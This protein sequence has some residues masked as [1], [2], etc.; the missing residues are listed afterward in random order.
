MVYINNIEIEKYNLDDFNSI[1]NRI[2]SNME[3]LPELLYFPGDIPTSEDFMSDEN[4]IVE[5]LK[6][7]IIEAKNFNELYENIEKKEKGRVK[8]K[9]NIFDILRYYILLNKNFNDEYDIIISQDFDTETFL[10]TLLNDVNKI[11]DGKNM[12]LDSIDSII[13]RRENLKNNFYKDI[14]KLIN[15]WNDNSVNLKLFKKFEDIKGV[16]YSKFELEKIEY[17]IEVKLYNVTSILEIFNLIILNDNI[18]F[19]ACNNF[20]KVLKDFIPPI[21]WKNLFDKSKSYKDQFR[22]I[23]RQKNIILKILNEKKV[24]NIDTY[25]QILINIKEIENEN[26]KININLKYNKYNISKEKIKKNILSIFEK[27]EIIDEKDNS[28]NGLFYIPLQSLNKEV[29]LELIMNDPLFSSLLVVNEMF[30]G[31]TDRASIHIYF[32]NTIIGKVTFKITLQKIDDKNN[33][34]N[35]LNKKLYPV[36]SSYLRIKITKAGDLNKVELFQNLLSKLITIY[37]DK[38]N[39]IINKYIN[40]YYVDIG[41]CEDK[42]EYIENE[43]EPELFPTGYK[44]ICQKPVR[45]SIISEEEAKIAIEEGKNVLKFPK[46]ETHGISPKYFICNNPERPKFVNPGL[47]VNTLENKDK[48]PY[49]PCCYKAIQTDKPEYLNYYGDREIEIEKISK[50]GAQDVYKTRKIMEPGSHGILPTNINKLFFLSDENALYFRQGVLRDKNSFIN[51]V[52][53]SLQLK[54]SPEKL[55]KKEFIKPEYISSCKQEMY[56]YT[57]E[58]IIKL[59]INNDVYFDPKLFIHILELYFNCNIFLFS[60]ENNGK[61]ILPRHTKGY[62]KNKNNNVC[63]FIF[64]HMGSQADK[65]EYPQ[66]ELIIKQPDIKKK[67]T[68]DIFDYDDKESQYIIKYFNKINTSY[69]LNRHITFSDFNYPWTN[70]ILN[71]QVVDSYGK[72][73]AINILYDGNYVS[74]LTQ[75]IQ[76]LKLIISDKIYKTNTKIAVSV[77]KNL[78]YNKKSIKEIRDNDTLK[79]LKFIIGNVDAKIL[80]DDNLIIDE[81]SILNEYNKFKKLSRYMIEYLYWLFSNYLIENNINEITDDIYVNFKNKYIEVNPDYIYSDDI[82]PKTFNMNNSSIM[83]D[84]KLIVKSEDVLK[85][86]FYVLRLSIIRN[87]DNIISYYKKNMID[88]Y[89]IDI[90]DFSSYNNQVI[91]EGEK[92]FIRLISEDN[93][94]IIYDNINIKKEFIKDKKKGKKKDNEDFEDSDDEDFEDSDDEDDIIDTIENIKYKKETKLLQINFRKSWDINPYFFKNKLIN[95]K[96]YLAQ[97]TDSFLK[98]IEIATI[99]NNKKYNPGNNI[100]ESNLKKFTLYSITN[101][102]DIKKYIINEGED[103]DLNIKIIGYKLLNPSTLN[104]DNLYT[105]LLDI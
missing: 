77:L 94:N 24:K 8:Y 48:F 84:N 102:D 75:P 85:R 12:T 103:N 42:F 70:L 98:A 44:S 14:E 79:E 7:D 20:Y 36:N 73:R 35:K 66:C 92:S 40:E 53:N 67:N 72:T 101:K 25:T 88:N 31:S 38:C 29:M 32:E 4:I 82:I 104:F 30:I 18:P 71:S 83:L 78:K 58:E 19:A 62:F 64:E 45:P 22:N 65:A 37:N 95:N 81:K 28:L 2:A 80:I 61:L 56:D 39:E 91:I 6:K 51:C 52:L 3:T 68:I 96:L 50:K 27:A 63:I 15:N 11:E 47:F 21:K 60:Y 93:K 74:I 43:Y 90:I 1:I 23:D 41:N 105:V 34:L 17:T 13:L 97:N 33:I 76:P 49:L 54:K 100:Y 5:D 16:N 9:L 55:R 89:Y 26:C 99:W 69:I 86:L 57:E 87:Y 10:K 46:E 59:I